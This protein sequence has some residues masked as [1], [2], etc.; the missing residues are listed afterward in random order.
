MRSFFSAEKVSRE[1]PQIQ[2]VPLK[3]GSYVGEIDEADNPTSGIVQIETEKWII[4]AGTF[5]GQ[6]RG[7]IPLEGEFKSPRCRIA[8]KT[9]SDGAKHLTQRHFESGSVWKNFDI[10]AMDR[11]KN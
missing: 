5:V 1:S 2:R 3:I 10:T 9:E 7:N 11:G 4:P 6:F 8:V